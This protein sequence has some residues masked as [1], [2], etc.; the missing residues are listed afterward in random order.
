MKS[1]PNL[2]RRQRRPC[3]L[4]LG[5]LLVSSKTCNGFC[6]SRGRRRGASGPRVIA[7]TNPVSRVATAN[8]FG[9]RSAATTAATTTIS[10]PNV[11]REGQL[12]ES[13]DEND[14]GSEMNLVKKTSSSDSSLELGA[15][16]KALSSS[17]SSTPDSTSANTST[18]SGISLIQRIQILLY[19]TALSAT[20][21]LM[22]ALAICSGD[23]LSGTGVD[24]SSTVEWV[25]S[26]MP[27]IVGTTVLLA[28]VPNNGFSRIISTSL[29]IV[30]VASAI[31]SNIFEVGSNFD[32][33]Q[34]ILVVLSLALICIREIFYFGLAYKVEAA[35]AL[36]ALPFSFIMSSDQQVVGISLSVC[37]LAM[38]V[39]SAGK[40][41]EPCKED[42]ERSNSEFLAGGK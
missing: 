34:W 22:T 24:G 13:L 38:D 40:I 23:V 2:R 21:L 19:R 26:V 16:E 28:P 32:D 20:S 35:I 11:I 27:L 14:G 31:A 12:H 29:G 18:S 39:L 1:R 25:G 42:F 37:A 9:H 5:S 7:I 41:F 36:A 4:A 3:F 17:T 30:A 10:C 6:T 15:E 8:P 33:V